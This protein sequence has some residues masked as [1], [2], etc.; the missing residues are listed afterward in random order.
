MGKRP[1]PLG[2]PVLA[3]FSQPQAL[4]E[5]FCVCQIVAFIQIQPQA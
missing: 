3:A 5:L 4:K 1:V 2:V